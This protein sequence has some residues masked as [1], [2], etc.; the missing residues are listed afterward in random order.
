MFCHIKLSIK[1]NELFLFFFNYW[2]ILLTDTLLT[3]KKC[4]AKSSKNC[5]LIS[6]MK[7]DN[8]FT[9][10]KTNRN[11]PRQSSS[12]FWLK[13]TL[14]WINKMKIFQR[15]QK[16]FRI[17]GIYPTKSPQDSPFNLK[18]IIILILLCNSCILLTVSLLLK[19]K[20]LSEFTESS[21]IFFTLLVVVLTLYE[22]IRK[23]LKLIEKFEC[24]IEKRE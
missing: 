22:F 13:Q 18:N 9:L 20:T 4:T 15:M 14:F 17:L 3:N 6:E 11:I 16:S 12:V 2:P 7:I 19:V 5:N 23:I 10:W 8:N 24:A 1:C 21:Y